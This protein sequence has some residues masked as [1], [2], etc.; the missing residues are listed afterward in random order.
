MTDTLIVTKQYLRKLSRERLSKFISTNFYKLC[1]GQVF[2]I[3]KTWLTKPIQMI[4]KKYAKS[5]FI[6]SHVGQICNFSSEL[7]VINVIPPRVEYIDLLDYIISTDEDFR[8]VYRGENFRLDTKRYAYEITSLIGMNYGYFSAIQSGIK[9]LSWIPN[10][11]KHCSE[12]ACKYLQNQ[13]Y[14]KGIDA[15]NMTPVE[16][17]DKMIRGDF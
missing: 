11:K 2:T 8:I 4:T 3:G 6:P 17:Y 7:F 12:V 5:D 13:G 9:G 14:F 1:G 16:I 15:D 10:R